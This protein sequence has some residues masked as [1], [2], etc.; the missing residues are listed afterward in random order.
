MTSS[1]VLT[2]HG[3]DGVGIPSDLSVNPCLNRYTVAVDKFKYA[4]EL[5]ESVTCRT[6]AELLKKDGDGY[7]TLTFDDGLVSDFAVAFPVLIFY[8]LKATFFVTANNIGQDGYCNMQQIREMATAGMEIG[9]HGLT[10]QYLTAMSEHDAIEEIKDSKHRIEDIIG[11]EVVSYAPVG[12]HY[13]NWMVTSAQDAGYMAFAS[14]IPGRTYINNSFVLLRRNH[15]QRQHTNNYIKKITSGHN[16]FL[17][18]NRCR[19]SLLQIPKTVFGL[20]YY[21]AIKKFALKDIE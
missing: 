21:D 17:L 12:G 5:I 8:G 9:S 10:H 16:G 3:I 4:A 20:R 7:I 15:I 6:V 13:S 1:V 2:F 18:I 19:Y 14:M 11:A